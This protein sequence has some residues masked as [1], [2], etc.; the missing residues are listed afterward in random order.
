MRWRRWCKKES[1]WPRHGEARARGW[2]W[3]V[4]DVPVRDYWLSDLCQRTYSSTF[5]FRRW[6]GLGLSLDVGVRSG[7]DRNVL[8]WDC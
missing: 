6:A 2:G 3:G 8:D 7:N 4:A 5:A 1:Q